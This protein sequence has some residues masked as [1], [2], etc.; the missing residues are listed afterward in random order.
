MSSR[1]ACSCKCTLWH[2]P[3]KNHAK[4]MILNVTA[5]SSSQFL[6][7][8]FCLEETKDTRTSIFL[9]LSCVENLIYLVSGMGHGR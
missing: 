4:I 5:A 2:L 1:A 7:G 6:A 9:A 3:V 8:G